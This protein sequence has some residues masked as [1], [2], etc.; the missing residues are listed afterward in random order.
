VTI[1]ALAAVSLGLFRHKTAAGL[2][3]EAVGDNEVASQYSGVNP[4]QVKLVVY[5]LCGFCAGLAGLVAASDI[6]SSDPSG[7]GADI[8][9][10]AILACVI[11]GTSLQGGRFSLAGSIIGA[12]LIQTVSTTILTRGIPDRLT[13]VVKAVVI[14]GVCLLQ[15][16]AFRRMFSRKEPGG[17]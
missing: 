9:L 15:A 1:L 14:I 13:L 2:F 16:P 12:Y 11:G 8:E 17:A 4:R 6:M 7:A 3:I 10:D 5:A